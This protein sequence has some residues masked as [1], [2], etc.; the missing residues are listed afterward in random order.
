MLDLAKRSGLPWD[1]ILGAE[2]SQAYKPKPAS[3]SAQR[4]GADA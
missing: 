1:A 2:I 4:R 3:L